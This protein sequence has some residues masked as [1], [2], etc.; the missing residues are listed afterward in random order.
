MLATISAC[1][2]NILDDDR[3]VAGMEVL[4]KEGSQVEE[5]IQKSE[6][7][8]A[9]VHEAVARFEPFAIVC[10]RLFVLLASLR[11]LSFLYEFPAHSFM[12][13]LE[14]CLETKAGSSDAAESQRIDVLKTSLL[15]EVA[16]RIGRG[17]Q[18]EDKVVLSLL[19]A[20]LSS[21]DASIGSGPVDDTAS[22]IQLITQHFG[23]DFPWQGRSLN[24]L[25]ELTEVDI[26][27]TVP[28]LMC[29]APGHDVSGRVEA[30]ARD[31]K[32]DLAA[33][34][35]GSSE[36]FEAA[37]GMVSVA[38]KRGTWVMLKNVH[39]CADWLR[40][41][42]VK[43]LQ[44]LGPQTHPNFRI[45]ITSEINP[46]LPTGLLRICDKLVADAPTGIKASLTRF[47]SSISKERFSLPM[48]NR[49]YL[50]LGWT[51]AVIQE[52]L[53][54]V[55]TGWS[56][57][58]EWTEADATHALDV[59]DSLYDEGRSSGGRHQQQ[60]HAQAQPPSDPEKLP[61]D[62]IRS[63]LCQGVFGGR[64]TADRDQEVLDALIQR[65]F[66]PRSF[67]VD[68]ALVPGV[69][70]GPILPDDVSH[71]SCL[72]WISRLP[73]QAPPTWIGL[74]SSAEVEREQRLAESIV[75]KVAIIQLKCESDDA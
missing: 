44:G 59:I 23:D 45:F 13:T 27:A 64:I 8:M 11:E 73:L 25:S 39:L 15:K 51:H 52:R 33:V 22:L 3:V 66:V 41:T 29:S 10:R 1:E 43:K 68:F 32:K 21:G 70:D 12:L 65:M 42:L 2:G 54:F 48:R 30:M 19:L 31:L 14:H 34:A 24:V 38:T 67:D 4:M 26:G 9:Q 47:F 20:R 16:G 28:L 40:D 36:G 74:D 58:Y 53:R 5:Q 18:I 71:T 6:E 17:L 46:R 50:L 60:A 72:E 69:T 55:P 75:R 57:P 35:M 63:T 56:E 61:W 49:L 7:I 62:A 37:E